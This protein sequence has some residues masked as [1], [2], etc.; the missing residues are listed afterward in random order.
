[1]DDVLERCKWLPGYVSET[2]GGRAIRFLIKA[3]KEA[4]LSPDPNT[5]NGA[6]IIGEDN[7]FVAG[8]CNHFPEGIASSDP[9]RWE[10]P[11]KYTYIE[12]AERNAIF[13]ASR[14][15][16]STYHTDMFC[17]W[18]ACVN[19]ARAIIQAGIKSVTGYAPLFA[20][21][22]DRWKETIF[23]AWEMLH[24]AGV[25]TY[26]YVPPIGDIE[27]VNY[28]INF[29]GEETDLLFEYLHTDKP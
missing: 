6:V 19:C 8:D 29:N 16:R 17:L 10:R 23:D 1:M 22:P 2:W 12:H 15:G 25:D 9:A 13:K 24:E 14:L 26:L 28:H 21:T 20:V 7:S 11:A 27:L 3:A 4:K 5:Q 18:F